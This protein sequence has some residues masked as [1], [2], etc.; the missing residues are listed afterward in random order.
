MV[1]LLFSAASCQKA[2]SP[3]VVCYIASWSVY[4][5]GQ[6]KFSVEDIDPTLCTHL[7]YAFAGLN[8]TTNSIYSLDPHY[9]ITNG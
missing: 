3:V 6:G 7:V 4:R 2:D 8:S 1:L 5:K 9:D